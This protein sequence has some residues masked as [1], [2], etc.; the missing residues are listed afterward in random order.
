MTR[1]PM[2]YNFVVMADVTDQAGETQQVELMVPLGNRK[3][4]FSID[5]P[6]KIQAEK[7]GSVSFC[8]R[9]A[10]GVSLDASVRYRFDNGA[11]QVGR[12]DTQVTVPAVQLKSGLHTVE[13]I[14]DGDTAKHTFT[15]FSLDDRR[16]AVETDDWFFVSESQFP[17]NGKPVTVQVGSSAKDV[18]IVYTMIAGNTVIESGAVDKSNELINRKLTYKEEYGNGLLLTFAWVKEGKAYTHETTIRRPLP[19]MQLKMQWQTF[20]N[21]LTPGQKEEWT[22]R[23]LDPAGKPAKAQLMATLYDKS[24]DLLTAHEW[25]LVPYQWLPIANTMWRFSTWGSLYGFN[26][27]RADHLNV[28]QLEFS[29]FDHEIYPEERFMTNFGRR[30]MMIR[31]TKAMA[32]GTEDVA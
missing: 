9:N 3:T 14:C 24:L 17:N 6:E 7:G 32:T 12:T 23:I 21:R 19:D 5:A 31:G 27:K 4:A 29:H 1:Y 11:W 2:F 20:R 26:S 13:A 22:L 16:P 25:S 28:P 10:A 15:V 18:H 8:Q 30:K